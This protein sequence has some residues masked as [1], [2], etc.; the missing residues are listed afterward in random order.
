M[1]AAAAKRSSESRGAAARGNA[2]RAEP[3]P[4]ANR[5]LANEM[6]LG[7]TPVRVSPAARA[8]AQAEV[9][10]LRGRRAGT[11]RTIEDSKRFCRP[12]AGGRAMAWMAR[13]LPF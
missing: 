2:R 9:R 10:D 7:G 11:I 3:A 6:A 5:R 13:R 4:A 1:H 8:P 12:V